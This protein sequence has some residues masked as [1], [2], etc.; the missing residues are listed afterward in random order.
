M[1]SC[2]SCVSL[3]AGCSDAGKPEDAERQEATKLNCEEAT[4]SASNLDGY[5]LVNDTVALETSSTRDT[6]FSLST[7]DITLSL[8]ET[9][10]FYFAETAL[11]VEADTTFSIVAEGLPTEVLVVGYWGDPPTAPPERTFSGDPCPG[12]EWL[13]FSGGWMTTQPVCATIAVT[14]PKG[15]TK[16]R[17][18]LGAS[19]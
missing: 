18:P 9:D 7:A 19:C 13:V 4:G 10:E 3:T 12:E 15:T 11:Q 17:V 6:P 5:E 8:D 16:L 2:S 1:A 14:T